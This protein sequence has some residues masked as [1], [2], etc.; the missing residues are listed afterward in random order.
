MQAAELLAQLLCQDIERKGD[1]GPSLKQGVAKDRIVS[2]HDP[3]M[4]YGHKS[5]KKRFE[6]HTVRAARTGGTPVRDGKA[7]IAVDPDTQLITAVDVL[8]GNAYDSERAL[9]L[10]EQ[11]ERNSGMQVEETIGDCAYGDGATREQFDQAGRKLVARV[12]KRPN[13]GLFPKEDFEID[14]EAMTCS[15]PAG[16][17]T[18]RLVSIGRTKPRKGGYKKGQAFQFDGALCDACELRAQCTR[19][20]PGKGRMVSLHPQERLLQEARALQ[21][22]PAFKE[23]QRLRQASEHRL[24]RMVQL[25]LRQARYFGR[26]KTLFQAL[27]A[28]TVAN[29]SMIARKTGKM[30]IESSAKAGLHLLFVRLKMVADVIRHHWASRIRLPALFIGLL[31]PSQIPSF[32]PGF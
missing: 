27:M 24:A 15:C 18:G 8:P 4:R 10:V 1:G 20:G 29:L 12:P 23:Y 25:G 3:E 7:A 32:R 26:T 5:A 14:L 22:S 9:E 28:A 19:A 11:S 6:G 30:D 17:V 31:C 16:Q 2:V 13:R 21:R